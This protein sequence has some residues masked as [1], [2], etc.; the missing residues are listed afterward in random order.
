MTLFFTVLLYILA[1]VVIHECFRRYPKAGFGIFLV[2][3]ILLTPV[4][5]LKQEADWFFWIKMYSVIGASWLIWILRFTRLKMNRWPFYLAYFIAIV[6]LSEAILK[7]FTAFLSIPNILIAL[8]GLAL[9]ATLPNWSSIK[10]DSQKFNDLLWNTPYSW[11]LGYTFWDWILIY[12][13]YP[14]DV[15]GHIAVLTAPLVAAAMNRKLYMQART[16]TLAFY[17][18]V[19]ATVPELL[20][21][22]EIPNHRNEWLAL[23]GSGIAAVWLGF[24]TF[25]HFTTKKSK[26]IQ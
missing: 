11:I 26:T 18:M 3:P 8:S 25:R 7:S 23:A 21:N 20:T 13:V 22:V 24:Q 4:W 19:A 16:S 1:G 15:I 17:L 14:K 9:I 5:F 2:L 10:V 12:L 6:N